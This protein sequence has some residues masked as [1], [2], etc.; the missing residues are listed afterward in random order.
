MGQIKGLRVIPSQA[1]FVMAELENG[2]SPKSLTKA[3]LLKYNILIKDLLG[4]IENGN[5]IR[6]AVR[7]TDENN[8]LLEALKCELGV[9]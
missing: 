1:N 5:Y 7:D 2:V 4:K 9:K 3:L 6:L 8:K